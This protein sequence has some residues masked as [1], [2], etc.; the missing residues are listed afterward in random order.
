MGTS[1]TN[2]NKD[3][4]YVEVDH[5]PTHPEIY[6]SEHLRVYIA[7][8][9]PGESTL[10]HRHSEDTVYIVL[11]GGTMSTKNLKGYKRSSTYF[12]H[13][14]PFYN[15][16]WFAVQTIFTGSVSLPKKLFFLM[17]NKKRDAIHKVSA[18]S[19]NSTDMR[20]MGVEIIGR[21]GHC[22]PVTLDHNL[23]KKEYEEDN[24]SIFSLK[25]KAGGASGIHSC[26]FPC[27]IVCVNGFADINIENQHTP[28]FEHHILKTGDF[29]STE[30]LKTINI[31]NEGNETLEMVVIALQ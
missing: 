28:Q 13:S 19:R 21:Y 30:S 31:K 10:Y 22:R 25:L 1:Q 5:D 7:T 27:F 23:Y 14:F 9:Q 15:K 26:A 12:P 3:I 17:L 4:G 16:F 24:F 29:L 8:I 20:L 6:K 18:S 11:E 2:E